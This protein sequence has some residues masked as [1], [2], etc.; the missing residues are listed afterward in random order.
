MEA[1]SILKNSNG[2]DAE[3]AG[4]TPLAAALA[5]KAG[6]GK[7]CVVVTGGNINPDFLT[8]VRVL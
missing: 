6:G 5:G 7:V 1:I 8:S 4:A 3:G 2:V